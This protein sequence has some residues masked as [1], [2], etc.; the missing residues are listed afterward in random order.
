MPRKQTQEDH[1]R[2]ALRLPRDIHTSSHEA[3]AKSNRSFNAEI[4][5]RLE[6]SLHQQL[7]PAGRDDAALTDGSTQSLAA[8]QFVIASLC[9]TVESM[10]QAMPQTR[11]SQFTGQKD[12]AAKLLAEL[13]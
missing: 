3:A 2:T 1:Q 13:P 8:M 5:A 10:Y 11:R 4:V 9:E 7:P 12:R 6:S